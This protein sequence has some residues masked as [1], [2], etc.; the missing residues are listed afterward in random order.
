MK[1][2]IQKNLLEAKDSYSLRALADRLGLQMNFKPEEVL[3]CRWKLAEQGA[4]MLNTDGSVQQDG[5]GY[6]GTIRDGLGNVVRVYAG[7]SSRN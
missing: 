4:Y 3:W 7:C 2:Y 1:L 6:G 5:S